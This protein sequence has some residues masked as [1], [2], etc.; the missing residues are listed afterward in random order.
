[1]TEPFNLGDFI[2][3]LPYAG[4]PGSQDE[5]IANALIIKRLQLRNEEL[6]ASMVAK[7]KKY[8]SSSDL[9]YYIGISKR[10]KY[11]HSKAVQKLEAELSALKAKIDAKKKMEEASGDASP[12]DPTLVLSVRSMTPEILER[13]EHGADSLN[14][15]D[16][17][18]HDL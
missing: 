12:L 8:I 14:P 18:E 1:M 9:M 16:Q 2:E 4:G 17:D 7:G 5:Y 15:Q 6:R 11:Q 13:I 10:T 3:E